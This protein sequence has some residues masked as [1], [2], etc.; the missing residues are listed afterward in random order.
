M[1][2][3][4]EVIHVQ[5]CIHVSIIYETSDSLRIYAAMTLPIHTID[6]ICLCVHVCGVNFFLYLILLESGRFLTGPP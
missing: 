5:E 4:D 6:E 2:Y 1:V 3:I